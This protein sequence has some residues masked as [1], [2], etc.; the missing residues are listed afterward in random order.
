MT[1][2][3]LSL[4]IV[5]LSGFGLGLSFVLMVFFLQISGWKIANYGQ[6]ILFS[7]LHYSNQEIRRVNNMYIPCIVH[8][9]T[10]HNLF[11]NLLPLYQ[12]NPLP[13][14]LTFFKG[15]KNLHLFN[16]LHKWLILH[17]PIQLL[18]PFELILVQLQIYLKLTV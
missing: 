1:T 15:S 3:I 6:Y 17:I 9:L 4:K 18:I 5:I 10:I 2:T 16:L 14:L 11:N 8:R 7:F 12:V 13:N